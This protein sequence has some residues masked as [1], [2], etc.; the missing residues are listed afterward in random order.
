MKDSNKSTPEF[1]ELKSVKKL[2]LK[3]AEVSYLN[4]STKTAFNVL[5]ITIKVPT[6]YTIGHLCRKQQKNC[7]KRKN[8]LALEHENAPSENVTSN[9]QHISW[10]RNNHEKSTLYFKFRSTQNPRFHDKFSDTK[11]IPVSH[12]QKSPKLF[13][14]SYPEP[15]SFMRNKSTQGSGYD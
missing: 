3:S 15:S 2:K 12:I 14:I 11:Y 6:G 13:A 4:L 1:I 7:W 5:F 8:G 9:L 10:H